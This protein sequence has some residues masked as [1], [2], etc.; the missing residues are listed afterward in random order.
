MR[1]AEATRRVEADWD[2]RRLAS[3]V[4]IATIRDKND[5]VGDVA[6]DVR[7]RITVSLG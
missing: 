1:V 7:P 3:P 5:V 4:G 6:P 2:F